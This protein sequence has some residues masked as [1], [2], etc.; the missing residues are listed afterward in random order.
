MYPYSTNYYWQ[1]PDNSYFYQEMYRNYPPFMNQNMTQTPQSSYMP[2]SSPQAQPAFA[3][4][5]NSGGAAQTY[6]WE[7]GYDPSY[8]YGYGYPGYNEGGANGFMKK[9]LMSY[10]QD[11]KGQIDFDKMMSTTGQVMQTIQQV[12]PVVKGIGSFVKGMR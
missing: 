6:G 3:S 12:S 4:Q 5:G 7:Q 2:Y 9:N 11:D 1:P 10:F 8:M